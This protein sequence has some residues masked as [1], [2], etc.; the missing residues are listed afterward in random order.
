MAVLFLETLQL[1]ST[2]GLSGRSE[3]LL[4]AFSMYRSIRKE[5]IISLSVKINPPSDVS[6]LD[7]PHR[8][9]ALPLFRIQEMIPTSAAGWE[10][11][12]HLPLCTSSG[13]GVVSHNP[14]VNPEPPWSVH[15]S[16]ICMQDRMELFRW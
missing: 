16:A 13:G 8:A 14:H 1:I 9:S 15:I 2:L 6:P 10:E 5:P 4:Q 7:L 11:T 3:C 12:M